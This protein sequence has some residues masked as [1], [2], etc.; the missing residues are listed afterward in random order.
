MPGRILQER[1]P[2][3]FWT[4]CAAHVLDL[5]LEDIGK[6]D[7][8]TQIVEDARRITKYIYNHPWVL[9]LMREHTNG[10]DLVRPA[11]TRFATI[12]LTLQS[13]LGTLASL[14]Q[15]FVSQLWLDSNYSK[16]AEG[17]AVAQIVFDNNFSQKASE[18]VKVTSKL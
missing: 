11:A 18:I 17:E 14:K 16:K 6:L 15:M 1:H 13:I 8:V 9:S 2:T 4:P 3:L 12:F 10:R 7:W 5:L